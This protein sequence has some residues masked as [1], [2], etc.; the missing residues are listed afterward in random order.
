MIK[1]KYHNL[2][3]KSRKPTQSISAYFL[4]DHSPKSSIFLPH[5][6]AEPNDDKPIWYFVRQKGIASEIAQKKAITPQE[7]IDENEVS[8]HN[9]F[10]KK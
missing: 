1:S 10:N 2:V 3:G 5:F 4:L 8:D 6:Q 7:Q 9:F